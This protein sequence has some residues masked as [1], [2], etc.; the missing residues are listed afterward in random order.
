[1]S[2]ENPGISKVIKAINSTQRRDILRTLNFIKK[3]LSFTE[4]MKERVEKTT[5]SSQFSYHVNVLA[6]A[7]LIKKNEEGKYQLTTLGNRTG[8]LLEMSQEDE[9]T[10]IFSSLYLAFSNMTPRDCLLASSLL[11][12]IILF[13]GSTI[14]YF[15]PLLAIITCL[16]L[17]AMIVYLYTRLNSLIAMIFL[18]NILWVMFVPGSFYLAILYFLLLSSFIPILG[19]EEQ[20]VPPP[21][22][23]ILSIITITGSIF[24]AIIYYFRYMK[25]K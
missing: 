19:V 21:Y 23:L 16:T 22:N 7:G 6:D 24:I 8:L 5:S 13:V 3:P 18:S 1:M 12:V 11:P 25:G 14:I 15:N 17:I 20:L 10:A 9:K 4:L 2:E